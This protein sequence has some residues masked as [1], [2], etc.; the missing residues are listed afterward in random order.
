MGY[1]TVP[2][3]LAGAARRF[4]GA[5]ALVTA[6]GTQSFG[7]LLDGVAAAAAGL[8]ARG[9]RPGDRVLMAAGNSP[10]TVRAWLG[11]I[12]A[13]SLPALVNPQLTEREMAYLAQ[14]LQPALTLRG[15]AEL[16]E[17]PGGGPPDPHLAA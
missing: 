3:L 15:E 16:A 4:G 7:E 10:A 5:P 17:L 1:A 14:D 2:E 9:V 6:E 11:A 8:Q 13:G 12:Y